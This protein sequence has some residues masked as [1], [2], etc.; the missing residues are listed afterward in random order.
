MLNGSDY[1]LCKDAVLECFQNKNCDALI[2]LVEE[3][4]KIEDEKPITA[5][6]CMAL[7]QKCTILYKNANNFTSKIGDIFKPLISI[8]YREKPHCDLILPLLDNSFTT[9]L[10]V[11]NETW[12]HID[13]S[14]LLVQLRFS[15]I[16]SKSPLIKPLAELILNP[17]SM[18]E[19]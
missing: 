11:C 9:N 12:Q 14:V 13:L 15:I 17:L 5:Y 4:E 7:Y 6:I 16:Y 8:K 2:K 19:K 18:K 10:R 1:L 3:R